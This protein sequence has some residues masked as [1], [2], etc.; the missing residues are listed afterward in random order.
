MNF[1]ENTG[2]DIQAAFEEYHE[3]NPDV[4]K[5]FKRL[6]FKAIG[7]GK[8]R[9]SSKMILNVI[10]WEVFLSTKELTLFDNGKDLVTFKINDAYTSRYARMFANDFPEH[11]DK[12]EFRELRS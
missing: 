5:H 2:K 4:Y 6:A 9:I 12:L 7:I 3:T 10:R 8:K 1:K 11:E